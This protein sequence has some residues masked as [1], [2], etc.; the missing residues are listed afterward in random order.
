MKQF[1]IKHTGLQKAG[2]FNIEWIKD[3]DVNGNIGYRNMET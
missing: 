3:K 2:K 1:L